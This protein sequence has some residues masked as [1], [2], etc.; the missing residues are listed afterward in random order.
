VLGDNGNQYSYTAE[1]IGDA[2]IGGTISAG[3]IFDEDLDFILPKNVEPVALRY[4]QYEDGP[5]IDI[6]LR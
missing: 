5:T 2:I 6:S 1:F 4:V 3:D